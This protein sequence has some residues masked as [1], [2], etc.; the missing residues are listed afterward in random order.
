MDFAVSDVSTIH[1][2]RGVVREG[3]FW[4]DDGS[5]S[6]L[7]LAPTARVPAP[8]EGYF[9]VYE[10]FVPSFGAGVGSNAMISGGMSI[11]PGASLDEQVFYVAPK[12]QFFE[13]ENVIGAVGLFW[14]KPGSS[15]GSAGMVFGTVTAGSDIASL[16][17]TL[18]FPF[19][20]R[21]GFLEQQVIS[22]GAE[23]RAASDLK[24]IT[25]NWF[26]L[27]NG[28]SVFSFGVRAIGRKASFE[29]AAAT[30]T[31]ELILFPV[32]NVSFNW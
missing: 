10:L 22:V 23:V 12:F 4:P 15:N 13:R 16:S 6:R 18:A 2:L 21:S 20:S 26:S 31:E 14:V 8:G 9:G 25:E 3:E 1:E 24:F 27:G 29:V 17:A 7:F 5:D 32:V 19:S 30:S 28:E 11:V